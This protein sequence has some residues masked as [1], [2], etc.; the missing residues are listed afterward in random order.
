MHSSKDAFSLAT[1]Q[2]DSSV[3]TTV[4]MPGTVARSKKKSKVS[5]ARE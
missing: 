3:K 2:Q 1:S 5:N 4:F